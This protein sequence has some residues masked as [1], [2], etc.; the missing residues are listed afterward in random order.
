MSDHD[1][2]RNKVCVVCL[3]KSKTERSLSD[4]DIGLI[5]RF[6]RE[7]Y[8]VS[9]PDFPSALCGG[10]RLSLFKKD[11]DDTIVINV[12]PFTP[13][14]AIQLRSTVCECV[15]C[16]VAKENLFMAKKKKKKSGR[17]SKTVPLPASPSVSLESF[18][19]R[20]HLSTP[21]CTTITICKTCC[22]E[23]YQG[24]RH[25]CTSSRSSR[26]RKIEN[27]S[28]LI[29]S[30]E[31]QKDLAERVA[32]LPIKEKKKLFEISPENISTIS[33]NMNLSVRK[34]KE[35][36][37]YLRMATGSRKAV[38][39]HLETRLFS[40][41][42]LLD[43]FFKYDMLLFMEEES[44]AKKKPGRKFR[45]HAVVTTD[46]TSLIDRIISHRNINPLDAFVRV[47]LDGGG[48]FLK[49]CL[50]VF[51]ITK[52]INCSSIVEKK[53]LD[54]GVKKVQVLAITPDVPENYFEHETFMVG[55]RVT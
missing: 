50:S 16:Q 47:G 51:D 40:D 25:V 8:D 14:R 53:Y 32:P 49:I 18:S 35:L 43:D 13:D 2:C 10:C 12:A 20:H 1:R 28:N 23:I 4:R 54:S 46:I 29:S 48:G 6:A 19:R 34:T 21:S 31:T 15:I 27:L 7:N 3:Q 37:H 22:A 45:Q 9:N 33:K 52:P 55:G 30:P 38:G 41:R 26:K 36:A 42:H 39:S 24:C 17:P 5:Q 11:K 44:K